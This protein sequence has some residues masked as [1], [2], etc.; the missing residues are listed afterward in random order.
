[1]ATQSTVKDQSFATDLTHAN[2]WQRWRHFSRAICLQIAYNKSQRKQLEDLNEELEERC[3]VFRSHLQSHAE[4]GTPEPAATNRRE[5]FC[6]P[7][8]QPDHHHPPPPPLH[9]HLPIHLSPSTQTTS[10][11][12]S[13][14]LLPR[15]L[16]KTTAMRPHSLVDLCKCGLFGHAVGSTILVDAPPRSRGC[17]GSGKCCQVTAA[18]T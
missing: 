1:M 18:C 12:R 9:H 13:G 10:Q 7:A 11:A 5:V 8:A 15:L 16:S 6:R 4:M 2:E 3:L 17:H 14:Q